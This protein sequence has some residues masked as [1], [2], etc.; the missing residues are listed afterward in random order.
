MKL[1]PPDRLDR[2]QERKA[3]RAKKEAIEDALRMFKIDQIAKGKSMKREEDELQRMEV[4][5]L[6]TLEA[7]GRL[8]FFAVPNG[9][10]RSKIEASIMKGLGV[11]AGVP[12]L[13]I[14]WNR[15]HD[16]SVI[17]PGRI[18][19]IENKRQNGGRLSPDQVQWLTALN[20]QRHHTA[21]VKNF[22]E[23]LNTLQNWGILSSKEVQ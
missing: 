23:F 20:T 9:G 15:T 6:R 1:L 2:L 11:R 8:I 5:Y 4:Q 14:M 12:D 18:G 22:E 10:K 21:I 7:Q 19:F 13:V 17:R 3:K 16:N